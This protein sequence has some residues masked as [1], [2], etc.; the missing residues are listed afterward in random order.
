MDIRQNLK[1]YRLACG[2]TQEQA[3]EKLHTTRQTVSNYETGRSQPDLDALT[4]LG[5][6]YGVPPECLLYGDREA[7]KHRRLARAAW[8]TIAC[9]LL[10]LLLSSAALMAINRCLPL[11]T[12]FSSSD[13]AYAVFQIRRPLMDARET[14]DALAA[15][16]FFIALLVLLF[17][18][19]SLRGARRLRD[20]AAL[21]LFLAAGSLAVSLPWGLFDPLYNIGNYRI[22][23]CSVIFSALP[24]LLVDLAVLA[25][26]NW[27]GRRRLS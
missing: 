22:A 24:I 12:A 4:R 17:Q 27:R 2:M 8:I 9:R 1:H 14:V 26:R 23:A 6:I 11:P 16:S 19:L 21:F 25:L 20:R 10:L 3:A 13:P 5:D 15:L 18:D 7:Q